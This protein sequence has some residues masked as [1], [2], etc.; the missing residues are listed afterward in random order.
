MDEDRGLANL[1]QLYAVIDDG[2]DVGTFTIKV[3]SQFE[4]ASFNGNKKLIISTVSWLGGRNYF[5]GVAYLVVGSI[6]LMLA[7][8]FFVKHKMNPRKLGD[9]QYLVW[10]DKKES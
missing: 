2:L 9:S 3:H 1:P 7:L 6:S 5:L 4:V 8:F 10:S